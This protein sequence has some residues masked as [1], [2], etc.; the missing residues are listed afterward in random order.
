MNNT[1][2]K[3]CCRLRVVSTFG[4]SG[5]IHARARK[6]APARRRATRGGA[7]N[8]SS[9]R[10]ASPRGSPFS[11]TRVYFAGIA[12]IRD[13][14][15]SKSTEQAVNSVFMRDGAGGGGIFLLLSR[16]HSHSL[17]TCSSRFRSPRAS[18][19]LNGL[20]STI[21]VELGQHGRKLGDCHSLTLIKHYSKK[22]PPQLCSVAVSPHTRSPS[23][24]SWAPAYI[25][26][27]DIFRFQM[28]P[29]RGQD[30]SFCLHGTVLR[31]RSAL[32]WT[33]LCAGPIFDP[34]GSVQY[35]SRVNTWTGSKRF[36]VNRARSGPVRSGSERN[37][38]GPVQTYIL[39]CAPG[40][41]QSLL[42]LSHRI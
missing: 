36:H 28:G 23:V 29:V 5:E 2:S 25:H 38:P 30:R 17:G 41:M 32:D 20:N 8:Y 33:C 14:S 19:Q 9:P 18:W 4:D 27:R 10:G 21:Y 35:P 26:Y 11:R 1:A 12:K 16:P 13:Y 39:T 22:K 7:E 24:T 6:W 42:L 37:R 34:F 40:D 15:Q 31:N 3:I